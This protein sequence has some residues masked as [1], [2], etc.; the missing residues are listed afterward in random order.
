MIVCINNPPD[1]ASLSQL[2]LSG[3]FIFMPK[4]LNLTSFK[5]YFIFFAKT[6]A[7]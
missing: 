1:F 6:I 7:L 2:Q 4:S 3:E 5:Y